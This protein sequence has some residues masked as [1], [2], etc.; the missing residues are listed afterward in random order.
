MKINKNVSF[1][2]HN[3]TKR[4]GKIEYIVIHYV[5]ALGDAKDNVNYYNKLTTTNASADFFVGHK[6]DVWQYNPD[7][8][9]RYCWAVG[10][11]GKGTLY[12][13]A[14]NK[15][16]VHIEMCVKL[17][18]S[19]AK[20]PAANHKDWYITDETLAATIDLTRYLMDLYGIP[21][22]RVIR[23]YDVT[24]KACPGVVGWNPLS[25]SVAAWKSFLA[26]IQT[27]ELSEAC[28]KLAEKGIID[29]PDY[30]AKGKGYSDDNVVLLIKKF[31]KAL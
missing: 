28:K 29:S 10:G 24:S 6:G 7:P 30:W 1:G 2:I 8:K 12:G 23:H 26:A 21:A 16:T 14:T 25:G 18:G 19:H 22:S 31:A 20:P 5:G 9:A 3:T 27:N 11:T 4:P 15:N 17:K 13:K